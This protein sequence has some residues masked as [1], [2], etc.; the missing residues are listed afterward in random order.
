M[1]DR[2]KDNRR[3]FNELYD[4]LGEDNYTHISNNVIEYEYK[5]YKYYYNIVHNIV[6]SSLISEII[7]NFNNE[8]MA[9]AKLNVKYKDECISVL[10]RVNEII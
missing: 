10:A 8:G 9:Y 4:S 7:C 2:S 5:G 3:I 6:F 1:K